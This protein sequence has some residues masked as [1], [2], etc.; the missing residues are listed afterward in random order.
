MARLTEKGL[1]C[2]SRAGRLPGS[3]DFI[4]S[5]GLRGKKVGICQ[6]L[7]LSRLKGGCHRKCKGTVNDCRKVG[8]KPLPPAE[9]KKDGG[10]QPKISPK[11]S[12]LRS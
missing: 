8:Q 9:H 3:T 1:Q 11:M 6:G 7:V 5:K 12:K 2:F 10:D 4:G